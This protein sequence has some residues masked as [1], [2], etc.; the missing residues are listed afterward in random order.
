MQEY[1]LVLHWVIFFSYVAFLTSVLT[2]DF[3]LSIYISGCWK[4][5]KLFHGPWREKDCASIQLGRL[6]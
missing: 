1:V 5:S 2:T 3:R 4:L 6:H